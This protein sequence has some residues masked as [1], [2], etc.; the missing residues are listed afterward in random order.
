MVKGAT[1]PVYTL[2]ASDLRGG[3][4][5]RPL[6]LAV[7]ATNA[8]GDAT[9]LSSAVGA[10]K[11]PPPPRLTFAAA[12]YSK[13]TLALAVRCRAGAAPCA[14]TVVAAGARKRVDVPAGG[15]ALV[16]LV[17]RAAPGRTVRARFRPGTASAG[18]A[19]VTRLE[20]VR[21]PGAGGTPRRR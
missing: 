15:D 14:G 11:P 5:R 8:A 12:A 21:P 16:L 2:V 20:V 6:R 10:P 17:P 13:K 3:R 19:A 7:T 1:E 9:A 4:L 18:A